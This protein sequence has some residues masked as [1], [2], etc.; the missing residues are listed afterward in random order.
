MDLKNVI[1]PD[2][3]KQVTTEKFSKQIRVAL[4]KEVV[5]FLTTNN[6]NW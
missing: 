6:K 1:S 2:I 3:Y 5:D 4:I